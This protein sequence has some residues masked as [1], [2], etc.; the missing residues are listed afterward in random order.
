MSEKTGIFI[1][2]IDSK[3]VWLVYIHEGKEICKQPL[4]LAIRDHLE[5]AYQMDIDSGEV[6]CGFQPKTA[7]E[8]MKVT[9]AIEKEIKMA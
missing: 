3:H 6:A 9:K 4:A 2:E 8:K 1:D 5:P 7:I